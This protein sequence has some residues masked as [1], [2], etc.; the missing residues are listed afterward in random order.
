MNSVAYYAWEIFTS[1]ETN[2]WWLM[3]IVFTFTCITFIWTNSKI[4]E[5]IQDI[6]E[7]IE[8]IAR[9]LADE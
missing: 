4:R 8:D 1:L 3:M 7:N 2:A 6:N 5:A 9:D